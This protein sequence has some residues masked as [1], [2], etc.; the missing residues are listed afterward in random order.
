MQTPNRPPRKPAPKSERLRE[1]TVNGVR[2]DRFCLRVEVL[3]GTTTDDFGANV[4]EWVG[5]VYHCARFLPIDSPLPR[6][7]SPTLTVGAAG[8]QG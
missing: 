5:V 4:I 8:E 1:L 2:A 7:E 6:A 3:A